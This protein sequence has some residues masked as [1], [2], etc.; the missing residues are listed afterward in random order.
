[1]L[2]YVQIVSLCVTV[3]T[4]DTASHTS[5]PGGDD[6]S[7]VDDGTSSRWEWCCCIYDIGPSCYAV[8]D[9]YCYCIHC[10]D[11]VN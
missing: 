2:L 11:A 3:L 1:M 7:L 9:C 5:L 4:G 10:F 8:G 6:D